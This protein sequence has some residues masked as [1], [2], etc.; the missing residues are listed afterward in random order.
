[1]GAIRYFE[2]VDI[3]K[4]K[5]DRR[6]NCCYCMT[7]GYGEDTLCRFEWW[8]FGEN[9]CVVKNAFECMGG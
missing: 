8:H 3:R 6:D 9:I 7:H 1:M 2:A 5:K 4:Q